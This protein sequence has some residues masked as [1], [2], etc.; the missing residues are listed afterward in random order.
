[1]SLVPANT[2]LAASLKN[3]VAGMVPLTGSVVAFFRASSSAQPWSNGP[4]K[5]PPAPLPLLPL[6]VHSVAERL[7]DLTFRSQALPVQPATS[8]LA[9]KS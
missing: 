5:A 8:A 4:P 1:M 9:L 3:S 6:L 7:A 2:P